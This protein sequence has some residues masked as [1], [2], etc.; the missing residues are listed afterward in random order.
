MEYEYEW[1]IFDTY[2]S[3][4]TF[5]N[6]HNIARDEIIYIKDS[7]QNITLIYLRGVENE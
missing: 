3:L 6:N 5:L 4:C 2:N 1:E 7:E